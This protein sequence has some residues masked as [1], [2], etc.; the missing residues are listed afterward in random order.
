MNTTAEEKENTRLELVKTAKRLKL[1]TDIKNISEIRYRRLFEAAQDG[2]LLVDFKT[3]MILDVNKFLIDLLGY[4]K[5]EF[6]GKHLWEVGC[7]RDIVASKDNFTTLQEKG[8]VR[9]EDLPLETKQGKEVEVEF[10]SN[11]YEAGSTT[12]IQC[13][14]RDI[15][16]R[17]ILAN[18]LAL[19]DANLMTDGEEK[20]LDSRFKLLAKFL[21]GIMLVIGLVSLLGWIFDNDL[22][23][24]LLISDIE[25]KANAAV[26]LALLGLALNVYL[27]MKS[28][29][30]F[31]KFFVPLCSIIIFLFASEAIYEYLSGNY[32][33]WMAELFFRANENSHE[34]TPIPGLMAF[35]A[36]IFLWLASVQLF[37]SQVGKRWVENITQELSILICYMGLVGL[38][39]FSYGASPI[40]FGVQL[41]TAMAMGIS[42]SSIL[43]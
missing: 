26:C 41:S 8:F 5:D 12:I 31:R 33:P 16:S 15:S 14:I 4:S 36:A 39:S 21:G 30:V 40:F 35:S 28:D 1:H 10:V 17:K 42:I 20:N 37:L 6:L 38:I 18:R 27:W 34:L 25:I 9:F 23:R 13:N 2:I 19:S 7:F 32:N 24:T 29:N 11:A 22:L 43:F 3:G